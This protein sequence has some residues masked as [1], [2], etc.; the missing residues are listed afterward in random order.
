VPS[1]LYLY[2]GHKNTI[3]IAGRTQH[4]PESPE[5]TLCTKNAFR[6]SFRTDRIDPAKTQSKSHKLPEE[7]PSAKIHNT[8]ELQSTRTA[9]YCF[10]PLPT[11]TLIGKAPPSAYEMYFLKMAFLNRL[12]QK[13]IGFSHI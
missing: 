9:P 4:F 8:A 3:S 1:E 7:S 12:S 5:R 2:A 10:T 11:L 13:K 6:R